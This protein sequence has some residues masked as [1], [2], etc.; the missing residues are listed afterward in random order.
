MVLVLSTVVLVL[1]LVLPVPVLVL[2]LVSRAKVLVLVSRAKALVL[3]LRA[4][5]LALVLV[6]RAMVLVLVLILP[7]LVLTTS[8]LIPPSHEYA[9]VYTAISRLI[10]PV[11]LSVRY[12]SPDIHCRNRLY[13]WDSGIKKLEIICYVCTAEHWAR[14]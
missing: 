1:V 5:V 11:R 10:G 3:V 7:L 2:A 13:E 9:A 8:L 4:M 14:L 12:T 6:L